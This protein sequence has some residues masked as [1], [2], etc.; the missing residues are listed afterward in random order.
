MEIRM[1]KILQKYQN[2]SVQVRASFWFLICSFLQKGI[3][4]LTTPIFTRLLS[5]EDY[6]QY[7]A[8]NSWL[9]IITIFVSLN[10]F[11][12]VYTQGLVKFE[13]ERRV[14][15]SSMQ[16]LT[17]TLCL[18]W[19]AVYLLFRTFWNRLF[20][21][22]TVQML[23][24]MVMIWATAAFSFWAAE[25]RVT[26]SYRKLVLITLLISAAKP[27]V[28]I[29]FV[30][31]AQDKVTARILGLALVEL[32]GYTGLFAVQMARGK[33]FYSGKF[34]RYAL[35][36]NIPLVPH[37]LSQT[38]LAS[39]DRIM[40]RD[41]IGKSEAGIYN[42]AYQISLLMTLFNTAL[43]QTLS[44]WIYQ[45]IKAGKAGEISD[46]GFMSLGIIA[47]ANLLL[48]LLAPEAVWIFAPESYY[49]AIYVIPPVSMS[50]FFMFS[51]ELFARFEFYYE[52]TAFIMS[53]SVT[54]AVINVVTNY[55]FIRKYGYYAAG[56]T[57]LFCYLIYAVGHYL[58]MNRVCDS[59]LGGIRPFP[60]VRY[61]ML[62][63]G[64]MAAG[65]I[66]LFT[67]QNRILR[68]SLLAAVLILGFI[69][70]AR[71]KAAVGDLVQVRKSRK[72]K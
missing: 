2:M 53:A 9:G 58:M 19:T 61:W 54:G 8:F 64:F 31:H 13:E 63:G 50:V 11:Y 47:F 15:S 57:T 66:L 59:Y 12:G 29:F 6:G 72:K 62:A 42:L 46:V 32:V 40:I 71:V 17:L 34:W 27:A 33:V 30:I 39:A 36:F 1:G 4:S 25:Q 67:Y 23:A 35:M 21:L 56:Y 68:Y 65:F 7:G 69:F 43:S 38:V 24:M 52:K 26:Y 49:N 70:R 10:L 45:K 51:Y 28:G 37:Y 55:I 48:M 20:S 14:Y 44:P 3:S 22:T 60:P 16:G 18:G 41:M 5:T